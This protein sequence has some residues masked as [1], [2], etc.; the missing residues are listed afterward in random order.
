MHATAVCSMEFCTPGVSVVERFKVMFQTC[1]S[2]S[3]SFTPFLLLLQGKK[4]LK[5]RKKIDRSIGTVT[6]S[7]FLSSW[8]CHGYVYAHGSMRMLL[9]YLRSGDSPHLYLVLALVVQYHS[10]MC[11]L[12]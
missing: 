11:E 2:A 5:E 4:K 6:G 3:V 8:L 9:Q 1:L 12:T 7:P 10:C